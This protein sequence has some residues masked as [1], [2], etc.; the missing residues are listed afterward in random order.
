MS[1]RTFR[2][3]SLLSRMV[4]IHPTPPP[5]PPTA[6]ELSQRLLTMPRSAES[7]WARSPHATPGALPQAP[8]WS[9]PSD[10]ARD[11]PTP[12]AP[13]GG[14]GARYAFAPRDRPQTRRRRSRL[15]VRVLGPVS[16]AV[17]VPALGE[18]RPAW[19]KRLGTR[20][21]PNGARITDTIGFHELAASY[22]ISMLYSFIYYLSP[23]DPPLGFPTWHHEK[24]VGLRPA[25]DRTRFVSVRS[26]ADPFLDDQVQQ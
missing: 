25:L 23:L 2:P 24:S 21:D 8:R 14:S 18:V 19:R 26:I 3:S 6:P 9:P 5:V 13:D 15:P 16:I 11:K 4:R 12:L 20:S 17:P 22:M 1:S 7:S 10:F